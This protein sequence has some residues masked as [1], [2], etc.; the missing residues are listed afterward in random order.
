MK[1]LI[2]LTAFRSILKTSTT[3]YVYIH[4]NKVNR[5]LGRYL[6]STDC[7][8]ALLSAGGTKYA[9]GSFL[10]CRPRAM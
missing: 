5:K 1:H 4:A 9:F 6:S 2:S 8:G 7:S 10:K 3:T